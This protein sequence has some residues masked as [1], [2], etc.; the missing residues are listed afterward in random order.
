MCSNIANH[1]CYRTLGWLFWQLAAAWNTQIWPAAFINICMSCSFAKRINHSRHASRAWKPFLLCVCPSFKAPRC[2]SG[3]RP[4]IF[5]WEFNQS[6]V[7]INNEYPSTVIT[8]V[9]CLLHINNTRAQRQG[10]SCREDSV[11]QH[12]CGWQWQGNPRSEPSSFD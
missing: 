12:H 8:P 11:M 3:T 1:F 7:E 9:H 2:V 10:L 5:C 4:C 6:R